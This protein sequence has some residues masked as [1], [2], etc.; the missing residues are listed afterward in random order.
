M[1]VSCFYCIYRDT[2]TSMCF[3]VEIYLATVLHFPSLFLRDSAFHGN[4]VLPSHVTDLFSINVVSCKMSL[5]LHF[6]TTT[7]FNRLLLTSYQ[8]FWDMF[9]PSNSRWANTF[10]DIIKCLTFKV[11]NLQI[12]AFCFN[13]NYTG[14]QPFWNWSCI[15][16]FY[17]QP[18]Y[19]TTS[20]NSRT[21]HISLGETY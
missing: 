19:E 10:H 4:H 6:F 12:L 1:V 11:W 15:I 21:F 16:C 2:A 17:P 14:S 5:Q 18:A 3:S 8:L 7:Y 20:N 9:L 13:L